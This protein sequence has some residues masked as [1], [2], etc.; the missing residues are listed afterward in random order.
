MNECE[1][2]DNPS[3]GFYVLYEWD[4]ELQTNVSITGSYLCDKCK[5]ELGYED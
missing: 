5:T 3:T 1:F 2:C 4:E